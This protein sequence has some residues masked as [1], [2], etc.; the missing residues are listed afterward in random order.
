MGSLPQM[1]VTRPTRAF[2]HCGVDY[3][4]PV[5][6]RA[7]AGRG[8]V[9]RKA[10]IAIFICMATRAIHLELV[11]NYST[12]AFID[13]YSRFCARRGMPC[14]MYFDKATTFTGAD[15]EL[16]KIYQATL[17]DSNF[18][19]QAA[20]DKIKWHFIPPHA[21]HFGG[22]WETGVRSV[23]HHLRR[24]LSSHTLTYEEFAIVLC[25]IEACLN[26][27]PIGL[28][29]DQLTDYEPLTPGHV[30]IGSAINEL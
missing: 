14:A 6:I 23:K 13:A 8:V 11:G 27:R 28:L 1:H 12:S 7:S 17:R 19:N 3:A 29:H 4:G 24:V 20:T 5:A 16:A 15:C 26:S 10:Y 21:P 18:L 22:L 2:L 9:T 25:K 30:L